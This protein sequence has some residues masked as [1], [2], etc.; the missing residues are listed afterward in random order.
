MCREQGAAS[1]QTNTFL[2][3]IKMMASVGHPIIVRFV[4]VA[5]DAL[6]DLCAISEFMSD[7]DLFHV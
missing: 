2:P 1:R 6:S 3:E 4:E 7:G 5:W